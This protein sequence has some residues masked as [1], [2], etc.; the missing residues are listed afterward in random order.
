[1]ALLLWPGAAISEGKQETQSS[2]MP[3]VSWASRAR[4]QVGLDV[5][6]IAGRVHVA[7]SP[8]PHLLLGATFGVGLFDLH[9]FDPNVVYSLEWGLFARYFVAEWFHIDGGFSSGHH[10]CEDSDVVSDEG[11]PHVCADVVGG[12]VQPAIGYRWFYWAPRF[13]TGS[14]TLAEGSGYFDRSRFASSFDPFVLRFMGTFL[15]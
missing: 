11:G 9:S 2:A 12:Y 6:Y 15:D 5:Q 8:T 3:G 13:F 10:Q 4:L 7:A 14:A 1:V